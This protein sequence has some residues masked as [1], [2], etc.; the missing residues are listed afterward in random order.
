MVD[1]DDSRSGFY[2]EYCESSRVLFLNAEFETDWWRYNPACIA[3]VTNSGR[4]LVGRLWDHCVH[5]KW[6]TLC[7]V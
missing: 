5:S 4:W 1:V 3:P 7:Y 6:D 2:Q